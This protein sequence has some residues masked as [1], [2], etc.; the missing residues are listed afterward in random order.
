M[1]EQNIVLAGHVCIDHNSLDGKDFQT[2]GSPL[3]YMAHYFQHHHSG[4]PLAGIAPYG[5][6]FLPYR[7]TLP[8]YP[9]TPLPGPTMV[10]RNVVSADGIR[11]QYCLNH[12]HASPP[13]LQ[14]QTEAVLKQ[15]HIVFV[16]PLTPQ[17]EVGYVH[18]L[19]SLTPQSAVKVLLPQGY[20]RNI[21]S[22]G[23]VTPRSFEEASALLPLFDLVV[24]SDEDIPEALVTARQWKIHSPDTTVLV[25][26]NKQG[27]TLIG[28]NAN[29]H[30]ATTGV[31]PA[32]V[33]NP[34]GCGD[35]FAAATAYAY[36]QKK[37]WP[38]A[39]NQGNEAARE[40][41]LS[42]PLA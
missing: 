22:N 28:T 33:I 30:I 21:G 34:I 32:E 15:A 7:G 25:T 5:A 16:M 11:T 40:S 39:V 29:Q 12:E 8:L 18:K 3:M 35:V 13:A 6:D 10:Y 4:A 42:P 20:L 41:L 27:A 19:I 38:Q 14:G 2:W 1:Q 24:L 37:N 9:E 23:L 36:F 26:E 31:E 17:Y